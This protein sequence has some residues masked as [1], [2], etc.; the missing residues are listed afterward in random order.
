MNHA[1]IS[2]NGVDND[3]RQSVREWRTEGRLS[4]RGDD[5]LVEHRSHRALWLGPWV[6]YVSQRD[7]RSFKSNAFQR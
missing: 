5:G 7:Q 6:S 2:N 4:V 3:G 1:R